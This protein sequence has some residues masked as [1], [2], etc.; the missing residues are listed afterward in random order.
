[1]S[2][3]TRFLQKGNQSEPLI[4]MPKYSFFEY[5][6]MYNLGYKIPEFLF[7]LVIKKI[8]PGSYTRRYSAVSRN[9]TGLYSI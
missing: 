6:L 7:F 5:S 4:H 9:T 3:V 1:M 8:T 2:S